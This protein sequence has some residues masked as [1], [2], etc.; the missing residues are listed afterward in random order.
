MEKLQEQT[1]CHR[2]GVKY[3]QRLPDRQADRLPDRQ[4]GF[5]T[6]RLTD[7]QTDTDRQAYSRVA[8]AAG[9]RHSTLLPADV[10]QAAVEVHVQVPVVWVFGST[11]VVLREGEE[12]RN[13]SNEHLS[14]HRNG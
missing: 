11:A 13:Q 2:Q 10:A 12:T 9:E 7:R 6:D 4:T 3:R 14:R 1:E 8:E 5:Q